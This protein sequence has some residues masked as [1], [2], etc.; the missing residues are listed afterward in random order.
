[1]KTVESYIHIVCFKGDAGYPGLPGPP[2]S[3]GPMGD[4]GPAGMT[5][6]GEKGEKGIPGPVGKFHTSMKGYI[7][8]KYQNYNIILILRYSWSTRFPRS[9]G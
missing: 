5:V 3:P 7:M 9:K 2:G 6:P 1:M 4:I 8:Y